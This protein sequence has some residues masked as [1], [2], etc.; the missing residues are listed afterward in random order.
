M[1]LLFF[2]GRAAWRRIRRPR[3]PPAPTTP[4]DQII[5]SINEI[6]NNNWST[7]ELERQ[8]NSL[9]FERLSLS[10]DKNKIKELASKGQIIA[11]P[12]DLIKDPY[13]LEFLGIP[14][15]SN[16]L[17]KD[18]ENLLISKLQKFLLEYLP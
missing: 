11:K 6:I 9:L 5:N 16:Y 4:R 8:I 18:I 12:E 17:E 7:R 1:P 10:K 2:A 3:R 15:N 14:E 13:V